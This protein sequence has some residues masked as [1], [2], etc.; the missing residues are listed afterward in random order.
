[1]STELLV[2]CP[3][4][5]PHGDLSKIARSSSTSARILDQAIMGSHHVKFTSF[6]FSTENHCSNQHRSR[7]P[8]KATAKHAHLL[9]S[10]ALEKV[11]SCSSSSPELLS[12][13][14]M[15]P[16]STAASSRAVAGQRGRPD[17]AWSHR[18]ASAALPRSAENLSPS[19]PLLQTCS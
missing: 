18:N 10:S 2:T 7:N 12:S 16:A 3:T 15:R 1:M 17:T 4:L 13:I 6:C 5:I 19:I 14:S 8:T 11:V 9:K